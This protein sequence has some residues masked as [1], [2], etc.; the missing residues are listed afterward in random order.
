[1]H[2]IEVELESVRMQ[3]EEETEARLDLERQYSKANTEC[4]TWK[5]KYE[6]ECNARIEEVE[7]MRYEI[8]DTVRFLSFHK[9]LT[10]SIS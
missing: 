8:N 3:L 7:E 10:L 9:W 4:L 2:S 6:M 5:S 1:M